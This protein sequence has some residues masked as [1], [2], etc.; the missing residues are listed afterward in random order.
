MNTQTKLFSL[1]FSL[2]TLACGQVPGEELTESQQSALTRSCLTEVTPICAYKID[3]MKDS[4]LE[5]TRI[6]GMAIPASHR[7]MDVPVTLFLPADREE[8]TPLPVVVWTHGGGFIPRDRVSTQGKYWAS[9]LT[10]V[11]YAVVL[12][13]HVEPSPREAEDFCT[14]HGVDPVGSKCELILP[15]MSAYFKPADTI[16][17]IDGLD[18]LARN[19][20]QYGVTLLT[21]KLAV[22]GWSGGSASTLRVAGAKY[23][24]ANGREFSIR[25]ER[26]VAFI[27]VS[28]S[29][30]NR[31]GFT[32]ESFDD[33]ERPVLTITAQG[34][35]KRDA[36]VEPRVRPHYHMP[37]T[38]DKYQMYI[39]SDATLH[40]TM[41]LSPD[42]TAMHN[43]VQAT[44]AA[45]FLDAKV[46][47][48]S[49][50]QRY[51]ESNIIEELLLLD[52]TLRD[53]PPT[54]LDL[55]GNPVPGWNRR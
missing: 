11:G 31:S 29:G 49:K 22:G 1:S 6:E 17:V 54:S 45:A 13:S 14:T 46:K 34:D 16:A 9:H 50:A 24:L 26:P 38:G 55:E 27:A 32:P 4:P 40:G 48:N 20:R 36:P 51:L 53:V 10:Q 5:T 37:A 25:D 7:E 43:K 21:D 12:V 8:A 2:L 52:P 35:S 33:I 47:G 42:D 41:N 3:A 15:N 30:D 19:V 18:E 28:P 44:T 23:T 39:N